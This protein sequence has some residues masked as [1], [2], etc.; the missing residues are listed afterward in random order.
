[1]SST[2][3]SSFQQG[4]VVVVNVPYSTQAGAKRRPAVIVSA[5][6]FHRRLPDVLLCPVS[7]QPRH[8]ERP[9]P[10]DVALAGWKAVGLR[11]PS[12]VR[13][14]NLQAVDKALVDRILGRLTPE[15]CRRVLTGVRAAFAFEPGMNA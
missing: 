10:G 12:A 4:Q 15:D 14:S 6:T 5:E 8:L 1:M 2:T 11:H 9:G 13:I 7:S 3:T